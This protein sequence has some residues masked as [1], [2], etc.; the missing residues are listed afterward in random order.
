MMKLICGFFCVIGFRLYGTDFSKIVQ[1]IST[2]SETH[3][4]V[5]F[6]VTHGQKYQLDD[7][8]KQH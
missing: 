8:I 5:S 3:I 2:E 6:Y 4:I 7:H 1:V